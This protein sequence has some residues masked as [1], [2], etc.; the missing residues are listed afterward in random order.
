MIQTRPGIGA[1]VLCPTLWEKRGNNT[2]TL[3][4]PTDL[5]AW[6]SLERSI[7]VSPAQARAWFLSLADHP[8]RYRFDTHKGFSFN[9]GRI[10]EV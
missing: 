9:Q 2:L 8:E 7:K 10:G 5:T 6:H 4:H 1:F 3:L